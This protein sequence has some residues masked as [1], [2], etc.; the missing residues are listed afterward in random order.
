MRNKTPFEKTSHVLGLIVTYVF[1]VGLPRNIRLIAWL[2][3]LADYLLFAYFLIGTGNLS[4]AATESGV[5]DWTIIVIVLDTLLGSVQY[6][7]RKYSKLT[8]KAGKDTS[9]PGW[10]K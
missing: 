4:Y 10:E 2:F 8:S 9:K 6:I 3:L 1:M 7:R 5:I